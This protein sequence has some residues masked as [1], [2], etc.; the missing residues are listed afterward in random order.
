ML[1]A[2]RKGARNRQARATKNPTLSP[3]PASEGKG[4]VLV[5]FVLLQQNAEKETAYER[6]LWAHSS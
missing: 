6:V 3:S 1:A 2:Q 4:N 5:P